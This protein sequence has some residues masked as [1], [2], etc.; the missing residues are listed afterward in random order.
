MLKKIIGIF[1][2]IAVIIIFIAMLRI[3]SVKDFS[4]NRFQVEVKE[5]ILDNGLK[6]L[7]IEDS[8]VPV[9]ACRINYNVGAI[10]E[11]AGMTGASHFLEHM[12]FKGTAI[13]GVKDGRFK[14]ES[15]L[16]KEEEDL[17]NGIKGTDNNYGLE[18][19]TENL[20]QVRKKLQN[21]KI[22]N[23]L[24]DIVR[25]NG[26]I[27]YNA[28]TDYD[29]TCYM[30]IFPSNKLELW[31]LVE[32]DRMKNLALRDFYTEIEVVLEER[33]MRVENSPSGQISF[34]LLGQVLSGTPYGR[35]EWIIGSVKDIAGFRRDKITEYYK[36]YY[37]PNN[38][39][40]VL[41][42]GVDNKKVVE[43]AK[44]YFGNIPR[45]D[46]GSINSSL[47]SAPIQNK[48]NRA[49]IEYPASGAAAIGYK[50]VPAS[51]PDAVVLNF[52]SELLSGG[53]TS[54]LYETLV[55][56]RI[57]SE[58][59]IYSFGYKYAGM[60]EISFRPNDNHNIEE[61]ENIVYKELELLR[62]VLISDK[63]MSRTKKQIKADFV[64]KLGSLNSLVGDIV[65]YE[66]IVGDWRKINDFILQIK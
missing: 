53:K 21:L 3:L 5:H 17:I 42:G 2:F 41:A 26:G 65:D 20:K 22:L 4:D 11:N 48:E 16:F 61:I 19:L 40:I 47:F 25:K 37:A 36:T 43:F 56:T 31:F 34:G 60:M 1:I 7:V 46:I 8:E 58:I 38:A 27:N 64:R 51:H 18:I 33:R 39:V 45:S 57:A 12:M 30:C 54:L 13:F 50:T 9:V 62:N 10:N 49:I 52:I 59:K 29:Q 23:D 35:P 63:E 55:K 44:K 6:I 15:G 14:E 66:S 24:D 28:F 32:S